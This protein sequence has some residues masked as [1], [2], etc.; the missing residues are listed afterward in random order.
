MSGNTLGC[1]SH[2]LGLAAAAPATNCPIAGPSGAGTCGTDCEG[3][4]TLD[5]AICTGSLAQY[6]SYQ[7]CLTACA[8]LNAGT[9]T[10]NI[11]HTADN[12]VLC[13]VYHVCAA[14]PGGAASTTHCPHTAVVSA[15]C[16]Q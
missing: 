9:G 15:T 8:G 5:L 11:S 12:S 4:C 2:Y 10:Y 16:T 3:F 14:A 13:R 6:P 1:R 7:N